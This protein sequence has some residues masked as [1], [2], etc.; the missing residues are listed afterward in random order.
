MTDVEKLKYYI[1]DQFLTDDQFIIMTEEEGYKRRRVGEIILSTGLKQNG[2]VFLSYNNQ[3]FNPKYGEFITRL[4]LSN[5]NNIVAYWGFKQN[6]TEPSETMRE[7]HTGFLVINGKL[8]VTTGDGKNQQKVQIQGIDLR[9]YYEYKIKYNEFYMAQLPTIIT[10]LGVPT[11]KEENQEFKL[12]SK[13]TTYP[14]SNQIHYLIFFIKSLVN[15]EKFL[16]IE[17]II[18]KEKYAR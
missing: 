2:K 5:K 14:P 16:Y 7:S 4:R 15:S 12:L 6:L 18:Y 10:S 17:K 8:Y 1:F 9:N 11:I 13:N 3:I